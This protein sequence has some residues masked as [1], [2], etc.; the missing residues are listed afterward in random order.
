MTLCARTPDSFGQDFYCHDC[1]CMDYDG[2]AGDLLESE[3]GYAL[4]TGY[5][6]GYSFLFSEDP[7]GMGPPSS[8]PATRCEGVESSNFEPFYC[9]ESSDGGGGGYSLGGYSFGGYSLGGG[10]DHG[11]EGCDCSCDQA[12][13][14]AGE[15]CVTHV[16]DE[17]IGVECAITDGN[18][19]YNGFPCCGSCDGNPPPCIFDCIMAATAE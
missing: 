10:G 12:C 9:R 3:C 5:S 18:G 7:G 15:N 13:V 11:D 16:F 2:M 1:N 6:T 4:P 19:N 17:N 8:C 14:E